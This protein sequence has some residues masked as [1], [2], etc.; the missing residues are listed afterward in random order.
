VALGAGGCATRTREP[1]NL[2]RAKEDVIAY[3]D[4]G[5]YQRQIREIAEAARLDIEK[6]AARRRPGE[7]LAVVFDVDETLISNLPHMRAMDF[8]YIPHAWD[9]WVA[10]AEAPAIEPVRAVYRTARRLDVAVFLITGR[11]ESDRAATERNL[12]AIGCDDQ[13]ELI[14][15]IDADETNAQFKTEARRRIAARGYTII[16]NIGDQWSDL[17]GGGAEKTYKLPDPFYIM[18]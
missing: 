16:A 18:R 3:V 1:L 9:A 14:C 6:R 8:G 17:D 5:A 15:K 4:S 10:A 7:R 12:R 11:G 2:S 13:A